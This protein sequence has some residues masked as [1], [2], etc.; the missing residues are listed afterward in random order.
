MD[1]VITC[2]FTREE[3]ERQIKAGLIPEIAYQEEPELIED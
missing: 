3:I 2:E 1:K